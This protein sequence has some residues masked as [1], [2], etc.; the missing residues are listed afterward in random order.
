MSNQIKLSSPIFVRFL[1]GCSK[2]LGQFHPRL[3]DEGAA[4]AALGGGSFIPPGGGGSPPLPRP[5]PPVLGRAFAVVGAP[6]EEDFGMFILIVC[7]VG[8]IRDVDNP[9]HTCGQRHIL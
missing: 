5:P 8:V 6:S 1:E 9:K 3:A 7:E 4:A 2:T